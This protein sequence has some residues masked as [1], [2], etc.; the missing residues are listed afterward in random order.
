MCVDMDTCTWYRTF[1]GVT[2]QLVGVSSLLPK[3]ESRGLN[4][5]LQVYDAVKTE[6]CAGHSNYLFVNF[7]NVL[8]IYAS[9]LKMV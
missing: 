9:V 3:C 2:G 6:P 4:S 5:G 8:N 1:V 7:F